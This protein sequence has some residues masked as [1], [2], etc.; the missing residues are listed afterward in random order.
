M[1]VVQQLRKTDV[2]REVALPDLEALVARMQKQVFQQGTVLF[3]VGDLG[4]TMYIILAGQVKIYTLDELGNEVII[5]HYGVN[6]IFGEL[7][8]IDQQPRSASAAATQLLEVL[9]LDRDDLLH[10]LVERP[11]IGLAMMMSLA[12]RLRHTTTYLEA[13]QPVRFQRAASAQS[14]AFRRGAQGM[15]AELLDRVRSIPTQVLDTSPFIEMP[16]YGVEPNQPEP[17]ASA[18]TPAP[19]SIFDRIADKHT[20]QERKTL[21][22]DSQAP[23][24]TPFL[25]QDDSDA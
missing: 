12:Q 16:F 7:S 19:R 14:E 3:N 21:F 15:G 5:I 2:F 25:E 6:E 11:Q 23:F 9:V 18:S 17:D 13:Y 1:S 10:F 4:D 8:P 22:E 24:P 20:T